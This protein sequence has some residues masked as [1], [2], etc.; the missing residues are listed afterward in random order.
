VRPVK[1]QVDDL[2]KE[3]RDRVGLGERV[4]VTTLTKRMAEDLTTY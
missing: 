1:G 3:I 4:L 2:L